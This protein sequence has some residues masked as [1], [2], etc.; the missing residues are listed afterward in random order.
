MDIETDKKEIRKTID[1]IL[2]IL[3]NNF[4]YSYGKKIPSDEVFDLMKD[5][6][7]LFC[8]YEDNTK[9][10]GNLAIKR[11]IPLLDLLVKID[12]NSEHLM[13]YE[14]HLKNAYKIGARVSLEHYMVY[15]EWEEENGFF[16]IRYNIMQG[17]I[18]FLQEIECNPKFEFLVANMPSGYGKLIANEIPVLT[19]DGW[20]K[21]GELKVGDYVISPNGNFVKVNIVHP[22]RLANVKVTFEDGEEILCHNQH[23]W[24]VYDRNAQEIKERVETNYLI[25]NLH[26]KDGR[27]RFLIPLRDIVKGEKKELPVDPYTYGV[28]LGD[29]TTRQGKITQN[30]KDTIIFDYIPYPITSSFNGATN[31][32]KSYTFTGLATDL[33]KIGLCYQHKKVEKYI[34]DSYLTASVEQRLELLAGLIDTDGYLD[35]VKQRYIISTCGKKLKDDI[36][37][38]IST[39]GWRTCVTVVPPYIS[40]NGIKGKKDIYYI[41]FSPTL[42][43]PCKLERKKLS[44]VHK[45]RRIGISNI[46]FVKP[47]EGNCITVDGGLYLVGRTLKTT[48]NTYPEKI[49][50]AWSFGID[51]S[52]TILSICSNDRVVKGGSRAVIDEIKSTTFGEVFPHLQYDKKDKDFFL[53]E[54]DGEWKLKNCNLLASYYASTTESDVVGE[55]ASKRIHLDD[56][57]PDYKEAMNKDLNEKYFNKFQ[58]VWKKR[59]IQE[60][61]YHKIVITGTLWSSD[62]FI[63]RVIAWLKSIYKFYKHPKYPYT[64]VAYENNDPKKSVVC[65]IIQVPALDYETGKSVCPELRSTEKI[66][67]DKNAIEDYLFQTNFQQIPTDPETLFFSYGRLKTYDVIPS[68]DYRG[69]YA[70]IDANRKTGKDFFAMPIFKK[71]ETDDHFEYYLKDCLFTR[72]ATKDMYDMIVN[73]IIEHHIIQISIESNATSE[74]KKALDDRLKAMNYLFCEINEVWNEVPKKIRIQSEK[75]AIKKAL[76][77]PKK[78][79]FGINTDVG[80]FMDN[81]TTYNDGGQNANDDAPDSCAL[82]ISEIV[83]EKTETTEAEPIVGIRQYM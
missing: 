14:K 48:H 66:L 21:H 78:G 17:Y 61:K 76:V 11:Y 58:T 4:R 1:K 77:F 15:R 23:E 28:W 47:T 65:A 3:E 53:K 80:A 13:E 25:K 29:G 44:K 24:Y 20:K 12:K 37:T 79:L 43:V 40:T 41:S 72:E 10:C 50:E 36:V 30:N 9:E 83:E 70:V 26:N 33:H 31:N 22:K 27:N 39:F 46:E 82:F 73:K 6:Y 81:L 34:H 7:V 38:L 57:Y 71:V 5:L 16:K 49:S 75:G 45:Q 35:R 55:R 63:A 32:V 52:G 62:D 64:F 54:T 51:D 60:A 42:K 19:K 74:L 67:E 68:T 56:L 2:T 18:H 69:A 59:F 8:N